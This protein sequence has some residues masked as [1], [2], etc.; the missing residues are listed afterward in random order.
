MH[1]IL[2]LLVFVCF[3]I[4]EKILHE[5]RL[6]LIP[7]RIHVNGTRGKSSVVRLIAGALREAG[8]RTLAKTT[9]AKP[10][11]IYPDGHE[12]MVSRRGPSRIQ[13]QVRFV[14]KAAKMNVK[15]IVVECMALDQ[16]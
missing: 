2:I 16:I 14:K 7:I 9:G 13:E 15:A 12:E 8:V 4:L 11:L 1:F 6:R 3:L 10:T 5:R